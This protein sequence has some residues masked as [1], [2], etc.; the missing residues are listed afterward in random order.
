MPETLYTI[1]FAKKRLRTFVQLLKDAGVTK[2]VDTRLNNT[3]QLA[4]FAKKDDLEYILELVG[5]KYEHEPLL[6]PTDLILKNY[7]KKII[8][9]S[10]YE[11]AYLCLLE[12][13][14]ILTRVNEQIS[15]EIVCFLCSE[16][17][18]D[19]CHRRLLVEYIQKNI[20]QEITVQHLV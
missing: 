7:K 19:Q 12:E 3:S 17:K 5:V 4:G 14:R 10:E 8:T 13:R 18:P 2:L 16:D 9:W 1:G 20:P 11:R 15:G 6:A